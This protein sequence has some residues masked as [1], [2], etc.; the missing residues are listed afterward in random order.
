MEG[1]QEMKAMAK[2]GAGLMLLSFGLFIWVTFFVNHTQDPYRPTM[3]FSFAVP[4]PFAFIAM[5][6]IVIGGLF[7]RPK[8]YW[9]VCLLSGIFYLVLFYPIVQDAIFDYQHTEP[10]YRPLSRYTEL[11]FC[12][13]PALLLMLEGI[14]L[15]TKRQQST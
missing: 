14:I 5:V 3:D 7:S 10:G 11:I 9:I 6:L 12:I 15:F 1:N 8:N 4:M 2:I 13:P